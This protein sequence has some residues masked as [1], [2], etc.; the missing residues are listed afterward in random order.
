MRILRSQLPFAS[1]LL[2]AASAGFAHAQ[3][4]ARPADPAPQAQGAPGEDKEAPPRRPRRQAIVLEAGTVHPASGPAIEDGVVV[5]RGERIA[6]IG[7]KGEIAVPE[8]AIVR[9]FPTGHLY[10]GLVDAATDAFTD[11]NLRGDGGLDAGASLADDLRVRG[12]RDDELLAAGITTAYVTVRSPST[13]R[14]QGAIVRPKAGGFEVWQGRERAGLQMRMTNGPQ[15]SHPLQRQQQLD[16]LLNTFEGLEEY[17]KAKTDHEE[18]RKKYDK[19]FADY[20]AFHQKKKD[21]DK[22]KEGDKAPA[23]AP[24]TAPAAPTTPEGAPGQGR[25]GPGGRTGRPG[26]QEPPKSGNAAP[27]RDVM[28]EV[29]ALLVGELAPQDPPKPEPAKTSPPQNPPAPTGQGGQAA[30]P[31]GDKKDEG[32]KRPTWP[33]PPAR[34]PAKDT[35]LAV[36]DGELPLRIEAHRPDELRAALQLQQKYSIPLLVLEQAYGAA[37]V[38]A[39]I[40]DQGACV[41]LTEVLP[42]SMPEIY[43]GFDPTALP[44]ALQ[45]A[46]VP[47]AIASGSAR[48]AS[49]LPLMAAAAVGKG[50]DRDAAL[51]AITLWPAEILGVGKDTGSLQQGKFADVL[52]T[53]R[54]LF[55]SDCRVLFVASKGRTEF[56]AK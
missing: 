37:S 48:R 12:D 8:G 56:E 25:R 43:E 55:A 47:F 14:G 44:A 24:A 46:G 13:L 17:R 39:Q 26:G 10:P 16:S 15:P 40:A 9:S 29:E 27:D 5:I 51:R 53:D 22:P 52:V 33:K 50:L 23:T 35:L 3:E 6:A 2:L 42:H 32:P 7:K 31:A 45:A 20:L 21:G 28:A 34:D 1:T 30:P 54:P 11:A 18:A 38:V 4:P 36:L 19:E 49:L 41:V